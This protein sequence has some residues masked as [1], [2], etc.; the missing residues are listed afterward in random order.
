[1]SGGLPGQDSEVFRGGGASAAKPNRRITSINEVIFAARNKH[2]PVRSFRVPQSRRTVRRP[3]NTSLDQFL[4]RA[5]CN[6]RLCFEDF[7]PILSQ[8]SISSCRI[9][10]RASPLSWWSSNESFLA[11]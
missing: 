5:R 7:L 1:M 3:A 2:A 10:Y 8:K 11:I 4:Q 6:C 9:R